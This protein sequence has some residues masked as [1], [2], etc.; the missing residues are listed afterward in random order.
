MSVDTSADQRLAGQRSLHLLLWLFAV[1]L[2]AVFG[3]ELLVMYLLERLLP[4]EVDEWTWILLDAG[5]LSVIVSAVVL[6]FSLHLRTLH[7]RHAR[8]TL[9]LQYTLD[10]HAIVSITD[11]TGRITFANDHFCEISGY[12]REELLGQNHRILKS[13]EH[14]ADY[15]REMW[16]TIAQGHVWHGDICNRA[17]DGS[18][19]WVRATI[20][21]FL[22]ENGKP[23]EYIAIRTDI[24]AQKRLEAASQRQEMWLRTILDNIG[25]GVYSLSIDGKVTY[26][27]KEGERLLGWTFEEL[28][29][30]P[31]HDCIHHHRPDGTPLAA[32]QCPIRQAMDEN[33]I[34]RS[35]NESFIRKDGSLLPVKITGAP[36]LLEGSRLGSVAVFADASEQRQLQQH[37]LDAKNA[38]EK[39]ARLKGDFL[40]TMSHEI[41][42]PLNGVIGMTDLLLDTPLDAEQT[43][44]ARII[45]TSADTLMAIVSDIL[46]F[47]KIEA[48]RLALEATDFS[49]RQTVESTLDVFSGKREDD[50]LLLSSF[51]APGLPDH[52]IGDPTRVRQILLNF[53][54]NAIK[55]TEQGA[56]KVSALP[57]EA[58]SDPS[59][60]IMLRLAVND[61]G[62][63]ISERDQASLFLPF[64]QADSSTTRKYG[65]T[66]LGLSITK[67]L[68]EA[69]GGRVGVD[70]EPGQ[71][72][73][74][75]VE[76]PFAVG[77]E[78]RAIPDPARLL[79]HR[80][81][82][83][84]GDPEGA[85]GVWRT[86]LQAWG[87]TV[88]SVAGLAELEQRFVA[89]MGAQSPH[90][91]VLVAPPL[92]DANLLDAIA[93]LHGDGFAMQ[94]ICCQP[95][96][97]RDERLALYH[98]EVRVLVGPLRQ[99][100]LYH[101]LVAELDGSM[102]PRARRANDVD[103]IGADVISRGKGQR[104]LLA[105]DNAV[106]QQVAVHML[107]RLDYVVDVVATGAE[108]VVAAAS[109]RYQ[110]VLM[111]CQMPEMDGFAATRAIRI[112]EAGHGRHLPVIAMT[113]NAQQGDRERCLAAG[114]DDYISKPVD[115]AQLA[116]TLTAHLMRRPPAVPGLF[117]AR[118]TPPESDP[119]VRGDT[120]DFTRLE[121]IFG[122][123]QDGIDQ[124]L[125]ALARNVGAERL[126][127][128]AGRL[129][130]SLASG[131]GIL[132][133]ALVSELMAECQHNIEFIS[134][135]KVRQKA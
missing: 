42:T 127:D 5:L 69:M 9:R 97:N 10:H 68:A 105:E 38:A 91:L 29:S 126:A 111:D 1:M 118:E 96:A 77:E 22:G 75:W 49:L 81:V 98:Q 74:F 83:L 26:L 61:T 2:S 40:S 100:T 56:V 78:K 6:P 44:F 4:A 62:I 52:L 128:I 108:A 37:L 53:L 12:T 19:Y 73:T 43:E 55:F 70:S 89:A 41:R 24:S 101:A 119:G 8:N 20:T 72:S 115:A 18:L 11:V 130:S 35:G 66:G 106:N 124:L 121:E 90:D 23:E 14:P 16:R 88:E 58:G 47:S 76:L 65:G 84:A 50:S 54:S 7:L 64:T 104:V 36:L 15:Y 30:K 129:E 103:V 34:Y 80:R 33:R 107:N 120:I 123:D 117:A 45:K 95:V 113:A 116:A 82:I 3:G 67:R 85:A 17:K 28:R 39:A 114:M 71:G 87:V 13:G 63:G 131:D 25:E 51:I 46:D 134:G 60:R 93:A 133:A 57:A 109:G 102:P 122:D 59:G 99:S 92:R 94:M 21:P 110:L 27:N 79:G 32:D 135:R 125:T 48:G 86:Y 31:L 112:A 132:T